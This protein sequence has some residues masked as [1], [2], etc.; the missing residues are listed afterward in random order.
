MKTVRTEEELKAAFAAKE[1]KI[2]VKGEMAEKMVSKAKTAKAANIGGLAIIVASLAAVPFTGGASIGGVSAGIT[3]T[4][5]ELAILC[6]FALGIYGIHKG[7]KV[8]YKMTPEGPEVEIDPKY[9][10]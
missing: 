7:S 3:L 2:I 8:K 9:K 6:C 10:D 4:A 1:D 5:S